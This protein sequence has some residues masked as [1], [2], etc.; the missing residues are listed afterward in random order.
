MKLKID[1]NMPLALTD[2]LRAAGH[3]TVNAH[4]AIDIP[5]PRTT[6]FL[7]PVR[8]LDKF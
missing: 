1:E 3:D 2:F 7:G 4:P 5:R 6:H 8:N